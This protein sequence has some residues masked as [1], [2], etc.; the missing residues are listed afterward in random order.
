M[1]PVGSGGVKRAHFA[2]RRSGQLRRMIDGCRPRRGCRRKIRRNRSHRLGNRQCENPARQRRCVVMR[3]ATVVMTRTA[4]VMI[5]VGVGVRH[6]VFMRR[7]FP[8]FVGV[9]GM[10]HRQKGQT[11]QPE[12]TKFLANQHACV[13]I[14][15]SAGSSS[16][17][18]K[19][20]L[21]AQHEPL[22]ASGCEVALVLTGSETTCV[23]K[24]TSLRFQNLSEEWCKIGLQNRQQ[25]TRS[26]KIILRK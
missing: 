5:T 24:R 22:P 3:C 14:G 8:V 18:G 16:R 15:I 1:N 20:T 6:A 25:P 26:T 17:F 13:K 23:I 11:D 2:R 10:R 21:A 19:E 12:N 7:N 4:L 9:R